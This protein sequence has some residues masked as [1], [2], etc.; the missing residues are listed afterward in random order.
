[1]DQHVGAVWQ[2]LVRGRIDSAYGEI[3]MSLPIGKDL[4]AE[5]P[6]LDLACELHREVGERLWKER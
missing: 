5:E 1:V 2:R 3:S 4:A 6:L